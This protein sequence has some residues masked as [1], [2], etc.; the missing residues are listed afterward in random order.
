MNLIIMI[1]TSVD[2]AEVS[3]VWHF[4]EQGKIDDT[5]FVERF[6]PADVD[7]LTPL[8]SVGIKHINVGLT[9]HQE[10]AILSGGD[11]QGLGGIHDLHFP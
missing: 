5:S 9:V 4:L 6:G 1:L 10:E 3:D 8:S 7:S 2:V 11:G